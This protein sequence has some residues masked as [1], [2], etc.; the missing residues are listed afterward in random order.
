V[1][2]DVAV[3]GQRAASGFPASVWVRARD[4]ASGRALDGVAIEPEAD[5]SFTPA[6]SRVTTDATGWAHVAA[7]PLGYSVPLVL[8][9]TDRAGRT[10]LWAGGLFIA[11]GAAGVVARDLYGLAERPIFEVTV[12]T[13][14]TALYV[15]VDDARGRVWASATDLAPAASGDPRAT[16]TSPPLPPG[17]YWAVFAGDPAGAEHLGTGTLARP[18]FVAASPEAALAFGPDPETCVAPGDVR[19]L[20]R[21]VSAC[22]AI[23]APQ[24]IPRW[25]A[26]DGFAALR[27][28]EAR[29]KARGMAIALGGIGVAVALELLLVLRAVALARAALRQAESTDEAAGARFVGRAWTVAVG[30]LVGVLGFALLGA[31]LLRLS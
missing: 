8:H 13:T 3:L 15:E 4:G 31:M 16:I 21:A 26:L 5:P 23:V 12:P 2:L 30:V 14:R 7:T 29:Q 27:A 18:F 11:P 1:L 25:T 28:R 22:L 17:L 9:A 6:A 24:G 20:P 19:L 10:G